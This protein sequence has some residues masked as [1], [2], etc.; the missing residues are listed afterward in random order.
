MKWKAIFARNYG[1]RSPLSLSL[2]SLRFCVASTC[3]FSVIVLMYFLWMTSKSIDEAYIA[4]NCRKQGIT[5]R[6]QDNEAFSKLNEEYAKVVNDVTQKAQLVERSTVLRNRKTV[7][8]EEVKEAT[9][10]TQRNREERSNSKV[11]NFNRHPVIVPPVPLGHAG[12]VHVRTSGHP[13]I[14]AKAQQPAIND[15]SITYG[16]PSRQPSEN[17]KP[18]QKNPSVSFGKMEDRSLALRAVD[19]DVVVNKTMPSSPKSAKNVMLQAKKSG[20]STDVSNSTIN[21]G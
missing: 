9:Q 3:F 19:S 21:L 6:I 15:M 4:E 2:S 8:E 13:T 20:S 12:A 7:L 17:A 14:R 1:L 11:E 10:K 18:S 5:K 16:G